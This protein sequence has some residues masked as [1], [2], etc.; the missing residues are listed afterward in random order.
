MPGSCHRPIGGFKVVFEYANRLV[1][2]GHNITIVCAAISDIK[3]TYYERLIRKIYYLYRY[4]TRTYLPNRWFNL[5]PA[6]KILW[7]PCLHPSMFPEADI[8]VATAWKTVEYINKY[9]IRCGK[10]IILF[11]DYEYYM[12]ASDTLKERI[13]SVYPNKG[14]YICI[15]SV[16]EKMLHNWGIADV[17]CIPIAL[18][19]SVFYK[20]INIDDPKRIWLGFPTRPEKHKRTEKAIEAI[21]IV[22]NK[23]QK[24]ICVWSFGGKPTIKIPNWIKYYRHP[25]DETLRKLYNN[26]A[27]FITPSQYEGW[28]L[29]GTEAMAC[30]CALISTDHGGINSY[31]VHNNNALICQVDDVEQIARNILILLNDNEMR[32]HIAGNAVKDIKRFSWD[33]SV[34]MFEKAIQNLFYG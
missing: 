17:A 11:M 6:V 23:Y 21:N 13:K 34:L 24:P 7:L 15:S 12:S 8:Y 31:A 22:K 1:K 28:G 14:K 2:K 18:D 10:K 33:E 26:T 20:E 4:F 32:M 25:S 5:D 30:G 16:I 19:Q 29:P 9:P 3:M 27:I